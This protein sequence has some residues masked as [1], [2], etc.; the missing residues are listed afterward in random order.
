MDADGDGKIDNNSIDTQLN[1]ASTEINLD[2]QKKLYAEAQIRLLKDLPAIPVRNQNYVFARQ[3]NV[4]LGY[5]PENCMIYGYHITEKT[6]I[7]K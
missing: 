4:D 7:L 6:K 1:K 3:K 2:V 5:K